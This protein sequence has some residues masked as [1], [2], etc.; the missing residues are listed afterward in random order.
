MDQENSQNIKTTE[1]EG[2]INHPSSLVFIEKFP[3]KNSDEIDEFEI[4]IRKKFEVDPTEGCTLLFRKYYAGLC[5]HAVRFVYSK[6]I[7]EDIVGDLFLDF[8]KNQRFEKIK[9]S[10]GAYLFRTVRNRC[11]NH[12][13]S[14]L[15]APSKNSLNDSDEIQEP[16]LPEDIIYM[17]ELLQRI[18]FAVNDLPPV[19]RKVFLLNRFEGKKQKEIAQE[20]GLSLRTI[21]AHIYK[22]LQ[23][24]KSTLKE[25]E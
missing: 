23:L 10:Y 17:D 11:L 16:E 22:A 9:V 14:N 5:S 6:E 15:N 4:L 7:A 13:K 19:C 1:K 25:K 20:L 2:L 18:N 21:E 24:L 12:I 8:W 3:L